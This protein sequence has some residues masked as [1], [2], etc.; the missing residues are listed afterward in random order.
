MFQ[1]P[2]AAVNGF[3][4][5]NGE[6]TFNESEIKIPEAPTNCCMS[7]CA[8]CVWIEYAE[9]LTKLF[10]DSGEKSRKIIFNQIQD[11]NMKAFLA[12]E[13]SRIKSEKHK[14]NE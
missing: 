7:G 2:G 13:L 12:L 3:S 14:S 9:E 8:N 11:S 4:C 6:K 10:K 5:K 1:F